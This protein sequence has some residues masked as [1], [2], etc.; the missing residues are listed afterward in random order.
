MRDLGLVKFD[1]PFD[2]P[3]HAG[4]GAE[5]DLLPRRRSRAR[6]PGSTRPTS[7]SRST[8]TAVRQARGSKLT[9]RRSIIGGIEKMS[10]SKNNGVDPQALIEQYGADT[11]RLFMMFAAPPEQTLE[12]SDSGVEGASRFLRRVWAFALRHSASAS[13]P[14][15]RGR[16]S[17]RSTTRRRRCAA[18]CTA[19]AA[20]RLRLRAHAVQHGRVGLHE[21]AQHA[22]VGQAGEGA[23]GSAVPPKA[24]SIFLRMLY[25]VAPHI[26][27]A[28]WQE[29]GYAGV[30]AT[31]STRRG[32][33]SIRA[34][35]G[36]GRDRD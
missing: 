16:R 20:G 19:A 30:S 11:A 2:E 33:R 14:R 24:S 28:L 15:W 13:R 34:R 27:H 7:T 1:E 29:L 25:P 8:T 5:R 32:R 21:D 10:K 9:A 3:A 12:W 4:H 31:C 35:A 17:G 26:T 23:A 18:K 6:R 22:G 36:A